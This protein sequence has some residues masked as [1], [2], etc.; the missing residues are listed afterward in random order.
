MTLHPTGGSPIPGYSAD[1]YDLDG[2]LMLQYTNLSYQGIE[3]GMSTDVSQMETLHLDIWTPDDI[4]AKISPISPGPNE[5]AFD[6]DLTP[7][8]WT[9]FDI[10]LSFFTDANP[11][12]DLTQIIQFKFDGVPSGE[13]TIFVDNIYFYRPPTGP[14]PMA[15]TWKMSDDEGFFVGDG[16]NVFFACNSSDGCDA[17]RACYF[18]DLYIFGSDGSFTNDLGAESWIEGWQG[19]TDSCGAPVAPHDGSKPGN[20]YLR[21]RYRGTSTQR[22][23]GLILAYQRRSMVQKFQILLTHRIV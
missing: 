20:L 18:D 4:D 23:R 21:S 17:T 1:I 19:G 6:L 11:L 14:P 9:S 15:G 7:D 13:G 5:A 16:A 3:L 22:C 2:D 12:V 8:Q 10:P